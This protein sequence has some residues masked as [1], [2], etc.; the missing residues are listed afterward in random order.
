MTPDEIITAVARVYGVRVDEITGPRRLPTYV[1]ARQCA[2]A[3]L[4]ELTDLS[5]PAVA[6]LLGR[7]DHTTVLH[8]VRAHSKRVRLEARHRALDAQ[9]RERLGMVREAA[10]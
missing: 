5:S 10:E 6:K 3:M 4:R 9:V 1:V 7:G 8:G 2:M